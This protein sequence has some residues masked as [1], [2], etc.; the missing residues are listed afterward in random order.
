MSGRGLIQSQVASLVE[1]L[2]SWEVGE[3][4]PHR[5]AYKEEGF[6]RLASQGVILGSSLSIHWASYF[7]FYSI[8]FISNFS[9]SLPHFSWRKRSRFR[10]NPFKTTT[11]SILI[12]T[13][14]KLSCALVN[15]LIIG[16]FYFGTEPSSLTLAISL[17]SPLPKVI[18]SWSSRRVLWLSSALPIS[19]ALILHFCSSFL[20]HV[21]FIFCILALHFL[22]F[23]MVILFFLFC[24]YIMREL[25]AKNALAS[26]SLPTYLSDWVNVL[27]NLCMYTTTQTTKF[28]KSHL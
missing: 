22:L 17:T 10:L 14:R 19:N 23:P 15:M 27:S 21:H 3:Q 12:G 28:P 7:C 6:G 26:S 4:V 24:S 5:Q 11:P 16:G 9:L 2:H 20:A 18:T 1:R 8:C 13:R 25:V